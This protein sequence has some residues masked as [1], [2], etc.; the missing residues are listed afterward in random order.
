MRLLKQCLN[1]RIYAII[2]TGGQKMSYIS[3]Y[4]MMLKEQHDGLGIT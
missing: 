4:Q 3:N 2:Q 1:K